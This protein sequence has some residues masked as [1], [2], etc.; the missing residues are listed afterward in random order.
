MWEEA[1]AV[2][3]MALRPIKSFTT[4]L[5]TEKDGRKGQI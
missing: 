5:R 4:T 1:A 2:L 3:I